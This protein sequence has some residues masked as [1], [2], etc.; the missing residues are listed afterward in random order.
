MK[1]YQGFFKIH[2]S[3]RSEVVMVQL[4]ARILGPEF[5]SV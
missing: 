5:S 4:D 1:T 3:E 2:L